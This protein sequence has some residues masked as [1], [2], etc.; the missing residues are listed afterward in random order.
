M[1]DLIKTIVFALVVGSGYLLY[2]HYEEK[3]KEAANRPKV[4]MVEKQY[5]KDVCQQVCYSAAMDIGKAFIEHFSRPDQQNLDLLSQKMQNY[6][7]Q[8]CKDRLGE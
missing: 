2:Q 1:N 4:A 5:A 7:Y 8:G 3:K 6:C